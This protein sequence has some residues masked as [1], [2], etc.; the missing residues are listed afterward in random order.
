MVSN[1]GTAVGERTGAILPIPAAPYP[2]IWF[3]GEMLAWEQA[4]VHV[5]NVGW[6]AISAVFEGIRGYLNPDDG[7]VNIFRLPEHMRRFESSMR[8]Q[9]FSPAF[10]GAAIGQATAELA[11]A[12]GAADDVYLQPLAFSTG[13]AWGSRAAMDMAPEIYI[14][15]RPSESALLSGRTLTAGV[16][17][18]TRI[19][20]IS[21][22]PRIKAL[23]N[24]ANSRLASNEA[25]RHGYDNPI[26][27][28]TRGTVAESSGS[29]IFIVRDG[30]AITPPVTAS[31]LESITRDALIELIRDGLG[32]PAVEREI[33]RT[34]LYTADE[35]FLCGTA[36]EVAPISE[37]DGY[38]IGDGGRGDLTG[39]IEQLYH[40]VVRGRE[41]RWAH[42]LTRV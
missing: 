34:E 36:M 10:T 27:L 21:L 5:S 28:N 33:D 15:M 6:P 16:S 23:P 24:Y 37:I 31:I 13:A 1:S 11:R 4:L 30:A 42:W 35:A 19:S 32:V 18:W 9:R 14:T 2:Y 8:L 29:C 40:D 7:S 41:R 25:S 3:S 17:S 12:N 22:P 26:F 38:Q 20:D 39:R